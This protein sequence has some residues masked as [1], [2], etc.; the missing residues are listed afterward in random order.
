MSIH[1]G[2]FLSGF[3]LV[4]VLVALVIL[5]MGLLGGVWVQQKALVLQREALYNTKALLLLQSGRDIAS[6]QGQGAL[7]SVWQQTVSQALP[8]GQG[9]IEMPDDVVI[10]WWPKGQVS[11]H[12]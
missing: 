12:G 7:V 4:E 2:I 10:T 3:S 11:W 5:T 6:V 1:G 9:Q 8:Q